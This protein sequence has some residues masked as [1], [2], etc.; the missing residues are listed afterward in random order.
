VTPEAL[1][2]REVTDKIEPVSDEAVRAFYDDNPQAMGGAAFAQVEARVRAQLEAAEGASKRRAFIEPLEE[3]AAITTYLEPPRYDI[4][5]TE[6]DRIKGSQ[7]AAVTIVE[8]ADFECPFCIRVLPTLAR[9]EAEYGDEVR[10]VFRDLPL[11]IHPYAWPAAEAGQCAHAQGKFWEFHDKAFAANGQLAPAD[12]TRL[13]AEAGLDVDSFDTCV[14]SRRF[15][16]AVALDASRAAELGITGTPVFYVNGRLI[17][18]AESFERFAQLVED[19]LA[20]R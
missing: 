13:A 2:Q 5:V 9:I 14:N 18:G 6:R 20:R 10:L 19:E 1:M 17:Q 4:V 7:D 15:E 12:L 3:K 16:D 11:S 8:Y